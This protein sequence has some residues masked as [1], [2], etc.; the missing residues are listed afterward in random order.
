VNNF[1]VSDLVTVYEGRGSYN[2]TLLAVTT[3]ADVGGKTTK[4]ADGS[5]WNKRG[6]HVDIRGS[7]IQT[8]ARRIRPHKP[9]DEEGIA[10][11]KLLDGALRLL[12]GQVWELERDL[13]LLGDD[14]LR[15]LAEI[16]KRLDAARKARAENGE[17]E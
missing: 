15:A 11:Q 17:E 1:K 8:S 3:V 6:E 2:E 16:S 10:R 13:G 4:T 7:R 9:G 5:R 14:D 12:R